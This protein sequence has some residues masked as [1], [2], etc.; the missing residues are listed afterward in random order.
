MTPAGVHYVRAEALYADRGRVL[1]AAYA[2]IPERF[3]RGAPTPPTLSSAA[4]VSKPAAQ[5]VAH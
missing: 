1:A 2:A 3:V 4:W 5:E